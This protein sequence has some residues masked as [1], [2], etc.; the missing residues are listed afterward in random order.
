MNTSH[1]QELYAEAQKYMPGGVSSPVRAFRA[2]GGNPLFIQRGAGSHI[3]DADGNEFIDYVCSWGPLIAGHA[4]PKVV[5]AIQKAAELGTSY[6]APTE[7]EIELAKLI[8]SALPSVEMLRFVS[9]GTEATMS[10]LR[11]ARAYT[12]RDKIIKFDGCYHGHADGLLAK[13]GSGV[14]TLGL[15]DSPGVPQSY[16]QHTLVAPYN[17]LDSVQALFET[18]PGQIATIIVEPVAGNMG[19]VSPAPGFLQGLRDL[20]MQ[21]GALLIF[22]EVITGFRVGWS[23]AQGLYGVS[24]DLTCL[25]KIIGGGLPVGAY[26]GR[27]EIMEMIAPMGP[28][29]QAGTLSGNPLAMAAGLATLSL[30]YEPGV[31]DRLDAIADRLE[32]GL[33]EASREARVPTFLS[34]IGSMMTTFFTS[35]NVTDYATARTA[36]AAV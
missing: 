33:K 35:E 22:D 30:L 13:A 14:A 24:P 16:A 34:R 18:Y 1:S 11:L 25:G 29:Y 15:P 7:A 2:V 36:D 21:G 31:Y 6:G 28:V 20:T 26:G 12:G 19:V 27:R 10:A 3:Y 8:I 9:S 32:N 23:G 4:H 5:A 17:D